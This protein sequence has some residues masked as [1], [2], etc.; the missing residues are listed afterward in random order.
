MKKR[1][2]YYA[3]FDNFDPVLVAEYDEKKIE[4]LVINPGIIRHRRKIESTIKNARVFLT[5]Q[6][7]FG[8]FDA[9]I[10]GFT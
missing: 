8:S 1:E 6:K 9:Y 10:R 3:A 4:Q 7:E 5:I 2:N